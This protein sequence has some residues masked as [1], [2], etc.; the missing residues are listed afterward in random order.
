MGI[1][2]RGLR[3]NRQPCSNLEMLRDSAAIAWLPGGPV[4]IRKCAKGWAMDAEMKFGPPGS[5]HHLY[6]P[7]A[8]LSEPQ[9][10]LDGLR[11]HSPDSRVPV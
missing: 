7:C 5:S 2:R 1:I 8:A 10:T 3:G 4:V 9:R 11:L 6:R